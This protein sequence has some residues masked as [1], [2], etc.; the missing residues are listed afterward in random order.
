VISGRAR[1]RLDPNRSLSAAC[2]HLFR[3][4]NDPQELE[5]NPLVRHRL[6]ANADS[7]DPVTCDALT[8]ANLHSAVLAAAQALRSSEAVAGRLELAQRYYLII[9]EHAVRGRSPGSVAKQLGLSLRQF[10]R[11]RKRAYAQV[12]PAFLQPPQPS[13]QK[14]AASLDAGILALAQARFLTENA[15]YNAALNLARGVASSAQDTR[16][17]VESLCLATEL[18]CLQRN[19]PEAQ[20]TLA[21][22]RLVLTRESHDH[23]SAS[24]RASLARLDA[25]E[26]IFHN[27]ADRP[28]LAERAREKALDALRVCSVGG[29]D[30]VKE[31]FVQTLLFKAN[32]AANFGHCAGS[33]THLQTAASLL[34]TI[35]EPTAHIQ[36]DLSIGIADAQSCALHSS[37]DVIAA[38]YAQAL[39]RAQQ[40]GYTKRT[41]KALT[42]A[43][44]FELYFLGHRD[45]GKAMMQDCLHLATRLGDPTTIALACLDLATVEVC[46]GNFDAVEPLLEKAERLGGYDQFEKTGLHIIRSLARRGRRQYAAALQAAQAAWTLAERGENPRLKSAAARELAEVHAAMGRISDAFDCVCEAVA[47]AERYASANSLAATYRA[48]ARITGNR[49]HARQA[50]LIRRAVS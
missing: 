49:S 34:Q 39:T 7:A 11:D 38:T 24:A 28:S 8:L 45:A 43:A 10:Y 22:A 21:A 44:C 5:R 31:L 48:S 3:Y 12:G 18:L 23:A 30:Q 27:A 2:Q 4:L 1:V 14:T 35:S 36:I 46:C 20:E 42:G 13:A 41:L 50:E 37:P 25:T 29:E 15:K 26:A 16:R 19:L 9:T 6:L 33:M 47:L 17:R 40:L 32:Q